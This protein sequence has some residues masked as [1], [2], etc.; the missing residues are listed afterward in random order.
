[1]FAKSVIERFYGDGAMALGGR[2]RCDARCEAKVVYGD[3]V[4]GDTPLLLKSGT[5]APFLSRVDELLTERE[6]ATYHET[7]EAIDISDLELSVWTER[8]YT[9]IRRIIRHR[10]AP[11][12]KLFRILTHTGVADVTEDHSLVLSD[13]KEA[14]PVDVAI[15]TELLHSDTSYT[16][17]GVDACEITEREAFVMGLFVA[18]GSSDIYATASGSKAT[19]AIN[20]AD[21]AL[22]E[23]AK[24]LCPFETRI[25]D[26]LASSGVYKLV[27]VGDHITPARKYRTM[28]YNRHREKRIPPIILNAP[29]PVVRDSVR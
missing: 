5:D 8:G 20:K 22:L 19:W 7:K 15:G 9:P 26:T 13:G 10:L 12:K 11:T 28:F 6:W 16:S 29:L 21:T 4:T 27:P 18:D 23:R 3:S 2:V 14:K 24:E 25:L 1:M 17:L